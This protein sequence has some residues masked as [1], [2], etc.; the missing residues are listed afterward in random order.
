MSTMSVDKFLNV[1]M[2]VNTN[3]NSEN[4]YNTYIYLYLL[5]LLTLIVIKERNKEIGK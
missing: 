4:P 5:T 3:V 2:I 1:N